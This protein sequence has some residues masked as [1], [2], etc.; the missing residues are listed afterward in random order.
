MPRQDFAEDLSVTLQGSSIPDCNLDSSLCETTWAE[1][2]ENA[3]IDNRTESIVSQ[4]NINKEKAVELTDDCSEEGEIVGKKT[5]SKTVKSAKKI[6]KT[7][8]IPDSTRPKRKGHILAL[9]K[10]RNTYRRMGQPLDEHME[11]ADNEFNP[12]KSRPRASSSKTASP[13]KRQ[14]KNDSN[15]DITVESLPLPSAFKCSLPLGAKN[16][17]NKNSASNYENMRKHLPAKVRA[18]V[19]QLLK[20]VDAQR[21]NV[22]GINYDNFE[23]EIRLEEDGELSETGK[24]KAVNPISDTEKSLSNEEAQKTNKNVKNMERQRSDSSASTAVETSS[25]SARNAQI[26]IEENMEE[27]VS[28]RGPSASSVTGIQTL[29]NGSNE[30]SSGSSLRIAPRTDEILRNIVK[31]I[32]KD[33]FEEKAEAFWKKPEVQQHFENLM[34]EEFKKI[35]SIHLAFHVQSEV[36][37]WF[38][39]SDQD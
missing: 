38:K 10:L 7:T 36:Q 28:N 30:H 39:E 4:T 3:K 29:N 18:G 1:N 19:Q 34:T 26:D 6:S 37:K 15:S 11:M 12:N 31:D 9:Q 20:S 23:V 17:T 2:D 8:T 27:Q 33:H 13:S 14:K 16:K 22:E 35:I 21:L 32:A 5:K 24:K 25:R